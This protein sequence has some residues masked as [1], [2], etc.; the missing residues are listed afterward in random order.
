[1]VLGRVVARLI[2]WE[3]FTWITNDYKNGGSNDDRDD[4][5]KIAD[6]K[7]EDE[8]LRTIVIRKDDVDG[9]KNL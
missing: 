3:T 7:E 4:K 1:M 2:P 5:K 8:S 9:R 6:R